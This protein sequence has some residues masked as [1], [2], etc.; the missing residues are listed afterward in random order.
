MFCTDAGLGDPVPQCRDYWGASVCSPQ[1]TDKMEAG[2][3]NAEYSDDGLRAEECSGAG[4]MRIG[5]R[6]FARGG[7]GGSIEPPTTLGGRV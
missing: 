3:L 5:S 1:Y 4:R 7:G 6:V 2:V